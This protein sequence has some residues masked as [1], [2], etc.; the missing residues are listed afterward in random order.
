MLKY[1]PSGSAND[2]KNKEQKASPSKMDHLSGA[3]PGP[4][5]G[6][7]APSY[8]VTDKSGGGVVHAH[9]VAD[10]RPLVSPRVFNFYELSPNF[11][12][13]SLL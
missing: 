3:V 4:A 13:S 10:K 1:S 7:G 11:E 6:G 2:P 9:S 8:R 5:M 12:V